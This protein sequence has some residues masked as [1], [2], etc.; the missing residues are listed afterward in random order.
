MRIGNLIAIAPWNV[1][2]FIPRLIAIGLV[3][4]WVFWGLVIFYEGQQIKNQVRERQEQEMR[5]EEQQRREAA[6][7]QRMMQE[8]NIRRGVRNVVDGFKR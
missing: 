7:K 6:Y 4:G 3:L 5:V 1:K 8:Q 2:N